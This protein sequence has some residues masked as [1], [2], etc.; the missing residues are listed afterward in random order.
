MSARGY[1]ST[2]LLGVVGGA[3]AFFT[4]SQPWS[5]VTVETE[6][7]AR[8]VVSVNGNEA[9]P[10]V[11]GLALVAL[12]GI[13]AVLASRGRVRTAVG[14]VVT[15]A[16]LAAAVAVA[17]GGDAVHDALVTSLAESP[18][19][20]GDAALQS[21]L[22][23]EASTTAWRWA[24]LVSLLVSAAAGAAVVRWGRAWPSMGS[25]YESVGQQRAET[26]D[27]DPWKALDRGEDPTV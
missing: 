9:L 25:R 23:D 12:A 8:D 5:R 4:A 11:G 1:G 16:S 20:A 2:V 27:D 22:A 3:A 13:V 18:A 24:C 21:R 14:V 10:V 15:L 17:L 7:L 6:G 26:V 19:M